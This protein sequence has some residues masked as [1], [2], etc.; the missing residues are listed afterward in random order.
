MKKFLPFLLVLV[1]TQAFSVN[2]YVDS[3]ATG[4]HDGRRIF[5][6]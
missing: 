4:S 6:V 2:Y 5:C 1:S 3:A